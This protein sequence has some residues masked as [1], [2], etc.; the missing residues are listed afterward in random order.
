MPSNVAAGVMTSCSVAASNAVFR[1]GCS[2]ISTDSFPQKDIADQQRVGLPGSQP[3]RLD[4]FGDRRSCACIDKLNRINKIAT[5]FWRKFTGVTPDC[6]VRLWA[7]I[8]CYSG[9]GSK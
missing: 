1:S 8:Y 3:Q 7:I 4:E 6:L 5:A 2:A 9:R